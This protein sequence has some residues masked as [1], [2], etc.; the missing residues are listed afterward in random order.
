M[1]GEVFRQVLVLVSLSVSVVS[2]FQKPYNKDKPPFH[3][4]QRTEINDQCLTWARA[5]DWSRGSRRP[6][7][8]C[9]LLTLSSVFW[10]SSCK[11]PDIHHHH[12]TQYYQQT[13]I[14]YYNMNTPGCLRPRPNPWPS[15]PAWSTC[16]GRGCGGW[17][18]EHGTSYHD[19]SP[20]IIIVI[21]CNCIYTFQ[22]A[23]LLLKYVDLS[24]NQL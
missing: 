5:W 13:L 1:D 15:A 10:A 7:T 16:A 4:E 17:R 18:S 19:K 22:V 21:N 2:F 14:I 11:T 3:M 6:R 9:S 12:H 20:N 24:R 23:E 8:A